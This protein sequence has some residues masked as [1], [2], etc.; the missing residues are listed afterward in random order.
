M[1]WVRSFIL[2]FIQMRAKDQKD[3]FLPRA[4]QVRDNILLRFDLKF[5]LVHLKATGG[6]WGK[7]QDLGVN[8]M[9]SK[10]RWNQKKSTQKLYQRKK[11]GKGGRLYFLKMA[12]L[13]ICS[14]LFALLLELHY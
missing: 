3:E 4:I 10:W 1:P 5:K 11:K 6:H 12:T 8:G 14:F 13:H 9:P 7:D 2:I